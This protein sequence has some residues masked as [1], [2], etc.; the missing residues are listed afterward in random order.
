[1]LPHLCVYKISASLIDFNVPMKKSLSSLSPAR[2]TVATGGATPLPTAAAPGRW[3][4]ALDSTAVWHLDP[5][6]AEIALL[7]TRVACAS[8]K[9]AAK[10]MTLQLRVKADALRLQMAPLPAS[11][12]SK[13]VR[14]TEAASGTVLD[15]G[16]R[17]HEVQAAW[18]D[19]V[20]CLRLKDETRRQSRR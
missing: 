11:A 9:A 7:T 3:T 4:L 10:D 8:H 1:M 18:D 17:L 6:L 20:V 12:L 14:R 16:A 19:F 5:A 2:P 13:V 15:K